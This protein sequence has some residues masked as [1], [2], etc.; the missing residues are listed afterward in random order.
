MRIF[1]TSEVVFPEGRAMGDSGIWGK[2]FEKVLI[3]VIRFAEAVAA[4]FKGVDYDRARQVGQNVALYLSNRKERDSKFLVWCHDYRGYVRAM[5]RDKVAAVFRREIHI[6]LRP[7]EVIGYSMACVEDW[8][9]PDRRM[10]NQEI[11][12]V[13]GKV[14]R[15]MPK[16]RRRFFQMVRLDGMTTAEAAREARTTVANVKRQL[17]IAGKDVKAAF[18]RYGIVPSRRRLQAASETPKQIAEGK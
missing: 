2:T 3:A 15:K 12:E 8:M 14:L 17:V 6:D 10:Q 11:S 9:S 16:Q 13:L 1:K 5:V 18:E 7:E 4:K